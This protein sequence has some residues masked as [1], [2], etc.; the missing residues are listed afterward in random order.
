MP[1]TVELEE[2]EYNRLMAL[3]GVA[4]KI[5]ANPAARRR[6]EEAHK[7]VDPNAST[8]L[9]D[10]EKSQ[11]E[12][13]NAIKKELSDEIAALKKDREDE[14][15]EATL[16]T[17]ADKQT[18]GLSRLRKAGYTDEGVAAVQKLM[19]DKG[20]L[21]VDDAVAIFERNHPPAI[22]ATPGGGITGDR[23]NFQDVNDTTDKD[24]AALLANKGEGGASDAA[25]S[26]L[27][28]AALMEIRGAR[29]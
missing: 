25:T 8:P 16:R 19:E 18:A 20:L 13:L 22:P 11:L 2:G 12:P 24:I 3:Q 21:D 9:L 15:R 28:N 1:K 4:S 29:R 23:W 17:I 6:L 5:V 26:R 10:Q 14:K 7:L 27:A